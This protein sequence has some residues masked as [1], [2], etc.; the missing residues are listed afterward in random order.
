MHG[1]SGPLVSANAFIETY[2]HGSSVDED[3]DPEGIPDLVVEVAARS[4]SVNADEERGLYETHR[5]PAN[6]LWRTAD[7]DVDWFRR[8]GCRYD[9]LP[10]S[11]EHA[12]TSAAA[13]A[14]EYHLSI[15]A[16]DSDPR[17]CNALSEP[18]PGF[19]VDNWQRSLP[20]ALTQA[21][22]ISRPYSGKRFRLPTSSRHSAC[23]VC[24]S[25]EYLG[26]R[27]TA[28]C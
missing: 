17:F 18:D 12:P 6:M 1:N 11:A 10:A 23:N 13:Q 26:F 2:R 16:C 9:S 14:D 19:H 22:P 7:R 15:N 25:E 8:H 28:I 27:L 5:M 20:I 4:M 21:V 24:S 3:G